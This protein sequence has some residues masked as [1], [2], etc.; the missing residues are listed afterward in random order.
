MQKLPY[1]EN[2]ITFFTW[3][4]FHIWEFS[5]PWDH[6][7]FSPLHTHH[8]PESKDKVVVGEEVVGGGQ[9]PRQT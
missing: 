6:L 5:N 7:D 8:S 9:V 4:I 3:E 1:E 2:A